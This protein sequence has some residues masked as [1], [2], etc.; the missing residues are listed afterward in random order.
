MA[1]YGQE[2]FLEA[3]LQ[4]LQ[5]LKNN[6]ICHV[7]SFIIEKIYQCNRRRDASDIMSV[8]LVKLYSRQLIQDLR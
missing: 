1:F 5:I 4:I 7:C 3:N 8:G 2:P 6:H